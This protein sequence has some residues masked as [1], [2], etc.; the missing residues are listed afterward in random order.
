[1]SPFLEVLVTSETTGTSPLF[2]A[3]S[4]AISPIYI[5]RPAKTPPVPVA[6]HQDTAAQNRPDP[7]DNAKSPADTECGPRCFAVVPDTPAATSVSWRSLPRVA[8]KSV[9]SIEVLYSRTSLTQESPL[10]S[11]GL[12]RQVCLAYGRILVGSSGAQV[13]LVLVHRHHVGPNSFP[14]FDPPS[15]Q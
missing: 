4:P 14:D 10:V 2:P 9:V 5:I 7:T 15:P 13:P 6:I 8:D 12:T 1:M 3:L 11:L